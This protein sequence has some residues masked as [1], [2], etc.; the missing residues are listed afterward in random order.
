[1]WAKG[2]D[3]EGNEMLS[4]ADYWK[5]EFKGVCDVL[6]GNNERLQGASLVRE[7]LEWSGV[8][9]EKGINVITPPQLYFMKT[10]PNAIRTIPALVHSSLNPED[11]DTNGEDHSYDAIRYL[12]R[13]LFSAAPVPKQRRY[14]LDS[15][16]AVIEVAT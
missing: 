5:Q 3:A 12:V 4:V 15:R 6:K 14:V 7:K 10:C 9:T 13:S 1:M 8:E 11:V 16:G 2:H